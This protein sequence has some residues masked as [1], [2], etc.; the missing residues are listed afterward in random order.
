VDFVS[1]VVE[2]TKS[3]CS[4]ELRQQLLAVNPKNT[5]R[6][7]EEVNRHYKSHN[8]DAEMTQEKLHMIATSSME[9]EMK[10]KWLEQ[11]NCDGAL[12]QALRFPKGRFPDSN[13]LDW[14]HRATWWAQ[15]C[16]PLII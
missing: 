4:S 1:L 13:F 15:V 7:L 16:C 11:W 14:L 6:F 8:E 2:K 9:P 3:H 10:V 5:P 12:R